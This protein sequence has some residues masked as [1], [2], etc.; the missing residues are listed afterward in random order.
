VFI[1]ELSPPQSRLKASPGNATASQ[2]VE[3]KLHSKVSIHNSKNGEFEKDVRA[4][5]PE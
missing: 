2:N 3:K 5:A 4:A 1:L